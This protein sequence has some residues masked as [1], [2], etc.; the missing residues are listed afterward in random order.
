MPSNQLTAIYDAAFSSKRWRQALDKCA[1]SAGAEGVMLYEFSNLR[2]VD[3]SLDATSSAFLPVAGLLEEY[4]TL[5]AEGRGSNF[6]QE[7][8]G[9]THEAEVYD[10]T[11][12]QE[13]WT[14][15]SDYFSRPE[16]EIGVR[17]GF[18]RRAL[19]N[20]SDD[21]NTF[22]GMIYLLGEQ[23]RNE[24]PERVRSVGQQLAP[25]VA[26]ALEFNRLTSDLRRQYNAALAVLDRIKTGIFVILENGDVMLRNRSADDLLSASDG[27]FGG[28]D[29]VLRCAYS[30]DE[31]VLRGAIDNASRVASGE[32]G[33]SGE[34]FQIK[35]R[36]SRVPLVAVVS[37]LRD[38]EMELEKDLQGAL[39]TVLDPLRPIDIDSR[40]IARAYE[41]TKAEARLVSLL[42]RGLTNS[43]I[44]S[45]LGI[46]P[47]TVKSHISAVLLKCGCRNRVTFL[48]RIF[49][50][51]PPISLD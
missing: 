26:R 4:N 14:L 41:L 51:F 24:I 28:P 34:V 1:L 46:G 38:A 42:A 19:V 43:E 16:V 47:E 7:G 27:L 5:L 15:D 45:E 11:F 3:F 50:L 8:L 40:L 9:A 35:R 36:G 10:V 44:A 33:S 49:Q 23:H 18:V 29:Q 2:R 12:D 37:P 25:H 22:R 20:L 48:W 21:P 30:E 32:F 13:V 17:A 39:L 6:D 31:I